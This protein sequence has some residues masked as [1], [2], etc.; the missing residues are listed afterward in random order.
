MIEIQRQPANRA[1]IEEGKSSVVNA[2]TRGQQVLSCHPV[3]DV[4][5]RVRAVVASCALA[6]S[7]SAVGACQSAP[8][9]DMGIA[10]TAP[11]PNT[12]F[13]PGDAVAVTVQPNG[14]T[15]VRMLIT[16]TDSNA[17]VL[18]SSP[19]STTLA[20][21]QNALGTAMIRVLA[22]DADNDPV[23]RR[24][25]VQVVATTATLR[26]LTVTPSDIGLAAGMLQYQLHVTGHYSDGIDRDITSPAAGTLY[27]PRDP[28][29]VTV[30]PNGLL[31]GVAVG[32][33]T[34]KVR[35]G[36]SQA[37]V[38]VRVNS[39]PAPITSAARR[40]CRGR[41]MPMP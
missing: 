8:Q 39:L 2:R 11:A 34:I 30:S 25:P 38:A 27:E 29:I 40:R 24:I 5:E 22:F 33:T 18:T 9:S 41:L 37:G 35:N 26:A 31:T 10:I 32:S 16:V 4:N 14:F 7:V 15:P 17:E 20:V 3:L 6:G 23:P 12:V 1:S 28:S 19:W 36:S 21:S 13:H